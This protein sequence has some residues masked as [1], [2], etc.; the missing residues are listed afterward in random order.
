MT[1]M[2]ETEAELAAGEGAAAPDW[3]EAIVEPRLREFAGRFAGPGDAVKAAF[4]MRQKLSNAVVVPGEGASADDIAAF[5]RRLGVPDSPDGYAFHAPD[6]AGPNDADRAFQAEIARLFHAAG[7]TAAQ[8]EQMTAGWNRLAEA[9][10]E[11]RQAADIGAL[12]AAESELRR[13]WGAE[14]ERNRAL[15]ARA[16]ARFHRGDPNELLDLALEGGRVL[17]SLPSFVR[18]AASVGHALAEDE[19]HL[20][21]AGGAGASAKER[22]D[23][24]HSWQFA[25][26]PAQRERYRSQEVQAELKE[27]YRSLHGDAPIVGAAGRRA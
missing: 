11:A 25:D 13:Q 1:R 5:R 20:G 3:R 16:V 19:V 9:S 7:V 22:L 8:A 14:F 10:R 27:L 24:I 17:G 18:F 26:D 6:G 4:E 15:A 23:E 2:A 21:G 12:E